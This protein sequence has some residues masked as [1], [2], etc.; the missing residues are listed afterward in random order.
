MN[1]KLFI[2][3]AIVAA[4][5]IAATAVKDPVTLTMPAFAQNITGDNATTAGNATAA[6]ATAGGWTK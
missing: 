5:G 2:V 4:F 1:T 6:N 3:V